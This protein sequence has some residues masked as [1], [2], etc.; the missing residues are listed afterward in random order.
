MRV[1]QGLAD[2]AT[3]RR[4]ARVL[5]GAG[6]E[7]YRR[8]RLADLLEHAVR[9]AFYRGLYSEA[10]FDVS[11]PRALAD[12]GVFEALPTIDKRLYGDNFDELNTAGLRADD[13]AAFAMAQERSRDWLGYYDGRYTVGMSSGTSGS[14]MLVVTDRAVAERL[15]FVF[16]ARS[17][18]PLRL[19]PMRIAFMLRVH[20]QAFEDIN[21]P[22]VTLRYI[23]TM[24]P[25][26]E[27]IARI[28]EL[29]ANVLMAPPSMLRVL[30]PHA[31]RITAP[32]RMIVAYAEVL[33]TSDAA[34][35]RTAFGV[36]VIQLYQ[37]SEGPVASACREGRLHLNEDLVHTEPLDADG[38]P[39]T[40]PGVACRRLLV[41]NLHNTVTP[42]V[43]YALND[44]IVLG[45]GCACGSGFR[46]VDRIIGRNDDVLYVPRSDGSGLGHV[47]PDVV[48]RWIILT[49]PE[50]EEY[51][52]VQGEPG[53]VTLR[54]KTA[55][56]AE[57]TRVEAALLAAFADELAR[58][59]LGPVALTFD[60]GGPATPADGGKVKRFIRTFE[61][62]GS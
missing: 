15:P 52:V 46:V 39:V 5:R 4:N 48:S 22:V 28:N 29:R 11:R 17:G 2:L 13:L 12:A 38:R 33:D 30:A 21:S 19:L 57:T 18:L 9:S 40:E 25:V 49:S 62:E 53:A 8:E 61:V 42:I 6:L 35:I 1:L 58:A 51:Q 7:R 56:G 26:G 37:A 27:V 50:V 36:P 54:L 23:A 45:S 59:G 31:D 60:F 24:T 10:G 47:F 44:V 3:L 16:L 32:V 34:R 20:N 14:R 41:T 43:R 55:P